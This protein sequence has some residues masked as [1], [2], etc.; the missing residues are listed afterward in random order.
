MIQLMFPEAQNRNEIELANIYMRNGHLF[1]AAYPQSDLYE[2]SGNIFA[3][4]GEMNW[5]D[6]N[7]QLSQYA[8][9]IQDFA[10]ILGMTGC[11]G[12]AESLTV[13]GAKYGMNTYFNLMQTADALSITENSI[14][15]DLVKFFS[16]LSDDL[17]TVVDSVN[18]NTTFLDLLKNQHVKKYVEAITG[19]V[20]A[21][22]LHDK[23]PALLRDLNNRFVGNTEEGVHFLTVLSLLGIQP[24]A[25]STAYEYFLKIIDSNAMDAL[26]HGNNPFKGKV[27]DQ[28]TEDFSW[29]S[30]K[31]TLT[32]VVKTENGALSLYI[33]A[34]EMICVNLSEAKITWTVDEQSGAPGASLAVACNLSVPTED[35]IVDVTATASSEI[36]LSA[37]EKVLIDVTDYAVKGELTYVFPDGESDRSFEYYDY[38]QDVYYTIIPIIS[39]NEVVDFSVLKDGKTIES[40]YTPRNSYFSLRFS[41][42]SLYVEFSYVYMNETRY[43][44]DVWL[45]GRNYWNCFPIYADEVCSDNTTIGAMIGK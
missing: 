11:N 22:K 34:E 25:G 30:F 39:D 10:D 19:S 40:T 1:A 23:L 31:N 14:S 38:S 12:T 32:E 18:K 33:P 37:A 36:R 15:T 7:E 29:E 24:D 21:T 41:S 27:F 2:Y 28:F 17:K 9:Y 4:M 16:T 5:Q 44:I 20:S 43:E 45:S 8:S 3:A 42:I 26:M 13:A 35:G 6:I